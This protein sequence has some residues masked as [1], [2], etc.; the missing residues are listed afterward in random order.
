MRKLL[1][2][3]PRLVIS[4]LKLSCYR[5]AYGS[6]LKIAAW[7]KVFVGPGSDIDLTRGDGELHLMGKAVLRR[8]TLLKVSA[9]SLKIGERFF[10]NTG[11]S[12]TCNHKI[13][14]G[15]NVLLGENV[16]IYDHDHTFGVGTLVVDE[17]L[18]GRQ[19]T[20][21]NNVWIGTNAVV[22]KG[23]DIGSDSVIGAGV[24][25]R[26]TIP[27]GSLV[28]GGSEVICRPIVG[29]NEGKG[30]RLERHWKID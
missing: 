22:L 16:H 10:A 11:S 25:V 21:G 3:L 2:V 6:R 15:E 14:I 19:V 23:S 28:T 24:I 26:G 1:I 30:E 12:I 4:V 27:P 7:K 18:V 5:L 29:T 9:G 13:S 8:N 20:I 17:G